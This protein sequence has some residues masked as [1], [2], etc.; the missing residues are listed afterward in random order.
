MFGGIPLKWRGYNIPAVI[1]SA[2]GKWRVQTCDSPL[3]IL[4][5]D[6]QELLL[7]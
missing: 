7:S 6:Q 3:E 2:Y 5:L 4:P 1:A